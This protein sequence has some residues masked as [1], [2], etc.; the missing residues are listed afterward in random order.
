MDPNDTT[1][2]A[3]YLVGR[4]MYHWGNMEFALNRAL[5]KALELNSPQTFIVAR[6]MQLRDKVNALKTLIDLGGPTIAGA[7]VIKALV[8]LANLANDSRNIV[9]HEAFWPTTDGKA[10]EFA[11]IQA[12][13]KF[14]VPDTVWTPEDFEDKFSRLIELQGILLNEIG[15]AL[16]SNALARALASN[17]Y[18]PTGG[19]F[20]LGAGHLPSL[21]S[22]AL[23]GDQSATPQKGG[24]TPGFAVPSNPPKK[25]K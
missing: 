11:R 2:Q 6:N 24:Q 12:K 7:R 1:V 3:Q 21:P 19:L 9:A 14:K 17:P 20:G 25:K 18:T 16:A 22:P 13:G 15:N 8:A 4:F 5:G 23:P 10:V